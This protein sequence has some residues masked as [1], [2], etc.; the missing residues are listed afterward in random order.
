MTLLGPVRRPTLQTPLNGP[1]GSKQLIAGTA[2][3]HVGASS[4]LNSVK[5]RPFRR[6]HRIPSL[7]PAP[8]VDSA[9][10]EASV[11][12]LK[13]EPSW[14][15]GFRSP[16]ALHKRHAAGLGPLEAEMGRNEDQAPV[17]SHDHIPDLLNRQHFLKQLHRERRRTD[18]SKS[19]LSIALFRI[20]GDLGKV[21]VELRALLAIL[22]R[23][24]RE[25][26]ILGFLGHG[27]AAV[28]LTDTD[29]PGTHGFLR[30]I[31]NAGSDLPFSVATATYPDNLFDAIL[32]GQD[33][34]AEMHPLVLSEPTTHR[35]TGYRL[36]RVIDVVGAS[37]AIALLSP[38]MLATAIAVAASSPG[39]IIFKQKRVGRHGKPFVFYKF[40]SM[41]H[42]NDDRIHQEFV[43]S[44]IKGEHERIDQGDGNKPHYKLKADPRITRV[45]HVIRKTSLDELPQLFN[46]LKGEMS[47]VG[48]RPPL[49]YEVEKYQSWHLRRILEARPGI[50]GLWQVEGRSKTTFDEMVRL[51]LR[52]TRLCSLAF[53]LKLLM[54]TVRAVVKDEGAT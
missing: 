19:P 8:V 4:A 5:V 20:E 33:A 37:V 32:S 26:D 9:R 17:P 34:G 48:P 14:R 11:A 18:R 50:T 10:K 29:A 36:K 25:T 12:V 24:K 1:I 22:H 39:P 3:T 2:E 40:R 43:I 35:P 15:G 16:L 51:D 31:A 38:V 52:Y 47:L 42:N 49:P 28:L 46:V 7:K 53:D 13:P 54:L 27:R 44:L 45:G 21:T 30:K 41:L 23:C 6:Q